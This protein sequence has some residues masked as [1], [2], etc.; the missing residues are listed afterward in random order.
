MN[1]PVNQPVN[2]PV[3]RTTRIAALVL[4]GVLVGTGLLILPNGAGLGPLLLGL[5]VLLTS[6][7]EGRYRRI[8]SPEAPPGADWQPTGETFRDE[9]SG[10]WVKVWFNP[11]TGERR[12]VAV[13]PPLA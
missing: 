1:R 8:G 13:E 5:V 2:R 11:R 9:E 10:Q 6:L 3:N 4:G 7:F 12:Y